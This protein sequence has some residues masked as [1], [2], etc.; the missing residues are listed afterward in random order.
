MEFPLNSIPRFTTLELVFFT[1]IAIPTI[2]AM[3]EGAPFVPTQMEQ[4]KRMLKAAKLKKGMK[5]YDLGSGD[6]RLCHKANQIYGAQA[7]GYEY[8]PLVWAWSQ[9]LRLFWHSKAKLK[10]GNFWKQDISDAD[11]IVSYLMPHSMKKMEKKLFPQLKKG[12]LIISHAFAIEGL[13]TWKKLPRDRD[14]K[15]GPV[16]IYKI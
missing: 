10:Y 11:V 5:V 4:V 3:I 14:R 13:K 16:W 9:F 8:S 1:L 2:Y 7:V 12:T 6:G 15:L